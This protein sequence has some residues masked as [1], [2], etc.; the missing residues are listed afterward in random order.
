MIEDIKQVGAFSV[1]SLPEHHFPPTN[2]Y[3]KMPLALTSVVAPV[4]SQLPLFSSFPAAPAANRTQ[5]Q[6]SW[7]LNNHWIMAIAERALRDS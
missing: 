4:H 1:Q 6:L 3:L 2:L 5:S 7:C